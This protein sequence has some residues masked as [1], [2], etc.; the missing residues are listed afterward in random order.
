MPTVSGLSSVPGVSDGTVVRVAGYHQPGDGGGMLV[1]WD[2]RS[3]APVNGGTVLPGQKRGRWL[4]LHEGVVDLRTFGLFDATRP[5]D[6]ALAALVN[7]PAV[8]R[9]EGHTDLLFQRRH[10]FTRSGLE[11]DFGG[12]TV[13]TD[14]IE[15]N[16]HDNPFGAVMFFRGTVTDSTVTHTLTAVLPDQDDV[17]EVGDSARFA[18]G[19]WWTAV[20]NTLAGG[21]ERELQKLV[22]VTQVVDAT[23]IRVNY[24]IGWELGVGRTITWTRVEPVERV[25]VRNM[26]F[27]G[28]PPYDGPPN[29]EL[30]DDREYT[31]SHPVAYEYAVRCDVSDVHATRTWWPVVMRR[32]CT[33][34]RTERS[35]LTNPP[36]VFYGGAG[37]LT[38]QIYCLY[39]RVADCHTANARHL[40]DWTASAYG[41]VENCHGDGDDAG[42]NPFTTHGQYEHDL[43][44]VGNSGLMDIANSG[45]QW[46]ISAKRIT[47]KR[48][49]CSWFVANTRITDLT[50]EDVHVVPRSTFDPGGTLTVNADG[51][52][53]RGC[54]A[55]TFAVAQR[56]NR[57]AR[58]NV[59][60]DCAFD[61]PP[62]QVL[63]QTPV[64]NTV[65]FVRCRFGN[66]T[67]AVLRGPG[68]VHFTDTVVDGGEGAAPML[69]GSAEV[70]VS[71]GR[72]TNTGLKL[73]A[74]RD[75]RL[76]V[77]G[78]A[79]LDG[80]N[81]DRALLSRAEG[82]GTIVW[83][84][85]DYRSTA[86]DGTA[87]VAITSGANR[88]S[89]L[90]ADFTGGA[91]RFAD[92]A[93]A[94]GSHLLHTHCTEQNVTRSVPPDGPRVHTTPNLTF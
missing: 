12:H 93:F 19:Q 59:I 50:L 17:F 84:L 87:H 40:N 1:R 77:G 24:R 13:R 92:A 91:L 70:V 25:H 51:V 67:G 52:Q 76:V 21:D 63:V 23:R 61:L 65:H 68:A 49:V 79:V 89:A 18:V 15:R 66:A 29:G 36:T 54:S 56:S 32:W 71:G 88:Y 2:A 74:V 45:A 47:V 78:G 81:T 6:D 55:S 58:P 44:F 33:F 14:G 41:I 11:L 5:A 27:V 53:L 7:D 3:A 8:H 28:A 86:A 37:Y 73:T 31:G 4:Q 90:G 85:G 80:T 9:V 94:D 10:T 62:D 48:H 57:S 22:Q 16:T 75:Q 26:V 35:S 60:A 20:V 42:G 46:G 30:P 43:V 69:V 34:F 82:A 38:Q 72:F 83:Q 39:G 64:T